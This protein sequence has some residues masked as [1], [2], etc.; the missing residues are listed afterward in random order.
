MMDCAKRATKK[1]AA[2]EPTT[3]HV[4]PRYPSG[5]SDSP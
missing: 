5:Q 3:H 2:Q 1:K 4:H